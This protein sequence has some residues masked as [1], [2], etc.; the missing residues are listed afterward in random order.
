MSNQ[1]FNNDTDQQTRRQV[2]GDTYLSRAQ[3]DAEIEAQGRFKKHNPTTITGIHQ[4]YPRQPTNCPWA[5][6]PVPPEPPLDYEIN[7]LPGLGLGGASPA[8]RPDAV[9][10]ATL[11]REGSSSVSPDDPSLLSQTRRRR[12]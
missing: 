12:V 6:Q 11:D 8:L 7:A 5:S 2:L 4:Q 10:T 1:P 3:A 9:E